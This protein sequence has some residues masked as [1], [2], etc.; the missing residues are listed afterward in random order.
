MTSYDDYHREPVD[1]EPFYRWTYDLRDKLAYLKNPQ[2]Y[3][4][5]DRWRKK[6]VDEVGDFP[7]LSKR[8]HDKLWQIWEE[9]SRD[10]ELRAEGEAT[11][12]VLKWER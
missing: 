3:D 2:H 9:T 12:D 1:D 4:R 11:E 6:F 8:R 10:A 7:V 5:L